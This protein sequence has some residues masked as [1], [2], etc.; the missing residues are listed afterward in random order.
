MGKCNC[1]ISWHIDHKTK[2]KRAPRRANMG[3]TKAW[4]PTGKLTKDINT[5]S[6][7]DEAERALQ[8][9]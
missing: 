5:N 8:I 3:E 2:Q 7:T 9:G 6:I 4:H 1:S